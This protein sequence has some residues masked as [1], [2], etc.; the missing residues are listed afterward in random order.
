MSL[1]VLF[2]FFIV[3]IGLVIALPVLN[4]IGSYQA[5]PDGRKLAAKQLEEQEQRLK[6][7]SSSSRGTTSSAATGTTASSMFSRKQGSGIPYSNDNPY[8]YE[9]DNNSD[10][11]DE[12]ETGYTPFEDQV[13][14][15]TTKTASAK[16]ALKSTPQTLQKIRSKVSETILNKRN[17]LKFTPT[18]SRASSYAN[19]RIVS[20]ASTFSNSGNAQLPIDASKPF[21]TDIDNDFD[22]D[23]FIEEEER[24]DLA[25]AAFE[26]REIELA[27]KRHNQEIDIKNKL[28]TERLES[29]A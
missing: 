1:V 8:A 3:V 6:A 16:E 22:Y 5:N 11:E 24:Q 7:N 25:E 23:S 29:L 19:Q 15:V 27:N 17:P 12:E 10:Q 18:S 26:K 4:G 28:A 20:S 21:S 2:A 13:P 9:G 14:A